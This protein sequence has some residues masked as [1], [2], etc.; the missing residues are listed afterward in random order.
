MQFVLACAHIRELD[1]VDDAGQGGAEPTRVPPYVWCAT[2]STWQP[3]T[4]LEITRDAA[5]P[6][7]A[8]DIQAEDLRRPTMT[9]P[10]RQLRPRLEQ[11]DDGS[12]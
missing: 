1:D 9:S 4:G 2:C 7:S 3:V 12:Q 5:L 6:A 11:H 10:L 8:A